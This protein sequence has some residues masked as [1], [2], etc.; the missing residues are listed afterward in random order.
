MK[1]GKKQRLIK[2]FYKTRGK[3][4]KQL[5]N[6]NSSDKNGKLLVLL[7]FFV[8]FR[9]SDEVEKLKQQVSEKEK[10]IQGTAWM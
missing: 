3:Y 8:I 10:Q 2:N 9:A 4:R 7:A 1:Y 5:E 6:S